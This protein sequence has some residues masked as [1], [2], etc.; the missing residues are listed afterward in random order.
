[1]EEWISLNEFMKQKK[2]GYNLALQMINNKEVDS[3]KT[4]GGHYKIKVGGDTVTKELYNKTLERA[5]Q[6][7]TK[8]NLLKKILEDN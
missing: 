3:I 2:I 6:A 7:E 4:H 1:M 8:L 5:I